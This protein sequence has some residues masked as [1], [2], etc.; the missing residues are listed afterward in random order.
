MKVKV[1]EEAKTIKIDP[2]TDLV[3]VDGVIVC[4]RVIRC[5]RPVLQFKDGDRLRSS[6]RG[7][8]FIEVP[9]EAF[10]AMLA[11]ECSADGLEW[12]Y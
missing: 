6:C 3:R 7:T 9:L 12:P 11:K 4:K 5:G 8:A 1:D 2:V 10:D